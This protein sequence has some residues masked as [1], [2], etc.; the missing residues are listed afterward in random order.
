MSALAPFPAQDAAT[1][2]LLGELQAARAHA[3]GVEARSCELLK[4]CVAL[5]HLASCATVADFAAAISEIVI[6]VVGSE[7]FA[8]FAAEDDGSLAPLASM[9]MDA[10]DAAR[11]AERLAREPRGDAG[12]AARVT[13]R[14]GGRTVGEVAVATL[15][16]HKGELDAFDRELLDALSAAAGS[17]LGGARLR[18]RDAAREL[19]RA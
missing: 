10:R 2:R 12:L 16:E 19:R 7:H 6:N 4:L 3:A 15:L 14:V 11:L 9:G 1:D 13:L 17:A 18:D 5:T 8:V